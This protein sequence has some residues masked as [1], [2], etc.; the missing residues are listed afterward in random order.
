MEIKFTEKIAKKKTKEEIALENERFLKILM[1]VVNSLSINADDTTGVKD[2][3][4]ENADIINTILTPQPTII[5][6]RKKK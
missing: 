3:K 4:L 5:D 1:K 2:V 6:R